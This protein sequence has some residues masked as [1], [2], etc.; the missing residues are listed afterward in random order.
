MGGF[1]LLAILFGAFSVFARSLGSR[2]WNRWMGR[3]FAGLLLIALVPMLASAFF[4][5]LSPFQRTALSAVGLFLIGL[6]LARC[7]FGSGWMRRHSAPARRRRALPYRRPVRRALG[8]PPA[9]RALQA[10]VQDGRI[11]PGTDLYDGSPLPLVSA[12]QGHYASPTNFQNALDRMNGDPWTCHWCGRRLPARFPAEHFRPHDH[13]GD[14][15]HHFHPECYEARNQAI[16]IIRG[17]T[18]TGTSETFEHESIH[19]ER[20]RW[21]RR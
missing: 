8:P 6:V 5:A 18:W 14:L 11:R 21:H 9:Y 15:R 20:H 12:H 4:A 16:R 10:A 13:A 17:R 3:A 2:R 7:L 1:I 19:I